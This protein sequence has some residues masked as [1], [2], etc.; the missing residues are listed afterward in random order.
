MGLYTPAWESKNQVIRMNEIMRNYQRVWGE[1]VLWSE[2]DAMASTK[3]SV[4]DEGPS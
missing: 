2:Y 4:Y 3:H 1:S